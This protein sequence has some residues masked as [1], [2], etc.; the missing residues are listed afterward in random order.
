MSGG[1]GVWEQIRTYERSRQALDDPL[2]FPRFGFGLVMVCDLCGRVSPVLTEPD[3]PEAIDLWNHHRTRHDRRGGSEAQ[4]S[5][6]PADSERV[7]VDTTRPATLSEYS[8]R[9]GESLP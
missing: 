7:G 5:G 6:N 2:E 1:G 9:E 8:R 3:S 4:R